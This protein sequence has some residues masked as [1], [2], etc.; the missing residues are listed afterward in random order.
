MD[1][2]GFWLARNGF[3]RVSRSFG[4]GLVRGMPILL[5]TLTI[6]GT[7]AMLWVG[8]SIILHGM[9]VL[10]M[11][12]LYDHIHHLAVA[13]A[14]RAGEATGFVEWAVTAFFGGIFGIVLGMAL[15]PLV[16]RVLTPLAAAI[17]SKK[18]TAEA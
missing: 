9:E 5:K 1:D 15:I 18:K 17:T 11:P 12:F 6:V 4:R 2:I 7:A 10:G 14:R 16:T 3:T 8:G 13:I